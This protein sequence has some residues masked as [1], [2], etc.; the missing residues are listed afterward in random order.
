MKHFFRS[1]FIAVVAVI[2]AAA[3]TQSSL[4]GL[5]ETSHD[6]DVMGAQQEPT[7]ITGHPTFEPTRQF[8]IPGE[9]E[10]EGDDSDLEPL[11]ETINTR[12]LGEGAVIN[13]QRPGGRREIGVA[14]PDG[15][16][17]TGYSG[18]LSVPSAVNEAVLS[19]FLEGEVV[20]EATVAGG[21]SRQI[22]VLF[23]RPIALDTAL[24]FVVEERVGGE[25]CTSTVLEPN[26]M[27]I[28][29]SQFYLERIDDVPTTIAD[30][31]PPVMTDVVIVT[32]PEPGAAVT[33]AAYNV[34][35]AMA[36]RYP[37][38]PNFTL[39]TE[40]D[41][42]P[43][44]PGSFS[45]TIVLRDRTE[46][47]IKLG[48]TFQGSYL[49]LAGPAGVLEQLAGML[50]EPEMGL[51]A[52][53]AAMA[54]L[55]EIDRSNDDL[56][57]RRSLEDVGVRRLVTSGSRVLQIPIPLPQAA[58]GE[59][60]S[61][62][63]I[64]VGGLSVASA[65][66]AEKPALSL[67]VNGN[68]QDSIVPDESGRFDIDFVLEGAALK[69]DN[70]VVIRSE[71]ALECGQELPTHELQIDAGSWVD[72]TPGQSLPP[73]LDRFPQ[74]GIDQLAVA[75]GGSAS[76]V[77]TALTMVAALQA[78]SPIDLNIVA[79]SGSQLSNGDTAGLIVTDGSGSAAK[80]WELDLRTV[81]TDDV[82]LV[83]DAPPEHL[84]FVSSSQSEDGSD[85]LVVFT[86]N[87]SDVTQL[88]NDYVTENGWSAF[89]GNV[90][91]LN[92]ESE[93]I[94]SDVVD[95]AA[96]QTALTSLEQEKTPVL[97]QFG[98][99]VLAIL[100]LAVVLL[101]LRGAFGAIGRLR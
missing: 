55:P 89:Q 50:S 21:T 1:F 62:I 52:N 60:V 99:G 5:P 66:I 98:F 19:I 28:L 3:P 45:R 88:F 54:D 22:E 9:D 77:S 65:S 25:S 24:E 93:V 70:L 44:G 17:L 85:V 84:A 42:P 97:K 81:R 71:I 40:L 73:S 48:Q 80:P 86:P 15:M 67:W 49:E 37:V 43:M 31:F 11:E 69:R 51:I 58:F 18:T 59:P 33:G 34:A 14:I 64:R 94:R 16:V 95:T 20:H 26:L 39:S 53:Q 83:A 23:D 46:P 68:L 56:L 7:T 41:N 30:F 4:D 13:L 8:E 63:Q 61:D 87:D 90:V 29:D 32:E 57:E 72:A 91:G 96:E 47:S 38:L 76:E 78:A 82:E 74:V 12:Q 36:R 75:S 10:G 101:A 79:V 35:A 100:L 2:A 27:R 92:V 6:V